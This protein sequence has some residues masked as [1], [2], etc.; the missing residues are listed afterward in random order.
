LSHNKLDDEAG[1]MIGSIIGSHCE[2]RDEAVW[3]YSIRGEKPDEDIEM[4]GLCDLNLSHNR[5]GSK[6]LEDICH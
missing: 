1:R 5:I 6:G 4:K 3:V 2:K